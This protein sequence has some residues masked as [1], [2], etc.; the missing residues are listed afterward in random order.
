[1]DVSSIAGLNGSAKSA[2]S[3]G[4]QLAETF[5][6][7]LT[8]LTTQ[9]QY[10][11]PLNPMESGEFTQQLVQFSSVEQQIQSNKNLETAVS[12]LLANQTI[13]AVG[14]IGREVEV[15]GDAAWLGAEGG[16]TWGYELE[17][18]ATAAALTVTD[19]TGKLVY[20]APAELARGHHTFTWDGKDSAGNRLPE[21]TYTL[22]VAATDADGEE[23][24]SV[25]SVMGTVTAVQSKDG[26]PMLMLGRTEAPLWNLLHVKNA[27]GAA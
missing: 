21:G 22:A 1:M 2:A 3:A 7:F 13:S 26:E 9:L 10:Q 18:P 25:V 14:Y 11:D 5:D 20:V 4:A 15:K 17:A 19:A 8:L 16:A 24:S 12:L 27:D 23:I 6:T